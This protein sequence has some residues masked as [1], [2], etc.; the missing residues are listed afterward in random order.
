MA[1]QINREE[2]LQKAVKELRRQVFVPAG[3]DV[4][5]TAVSCG[6]PGGGSARKR[7]GECWATKASDGNL[8]QVFIS[9]VLE[10]ELL[11]LATLAHEL[12][13]VVDDC[14]NGHKAP[15][16]HM[17]KAIGLAGKPTATHAGPELAEKLKAVEEKIKHPYPHNAINLTDNQKKQTTRMLKVVCPDD[18]YTVRTTRKWL[19]ELGTPTCPCGTRMEEA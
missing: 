9:P 2:W 8:S 14:E 16:V 15:F 12:V 6:F 3:I 19:D 10:G 5:E 11:V 18:D 1:R 7:I 17:M 4:P 13:H